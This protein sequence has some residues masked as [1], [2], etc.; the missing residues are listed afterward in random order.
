MSFFIGMFE[1]DV[2]HVMP[3]Q[4]DLIGHDMSRIFEH[5]VPYHDA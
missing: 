3:N 1:G 5:S 4:D 2:G